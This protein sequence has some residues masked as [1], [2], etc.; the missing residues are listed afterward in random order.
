MPKPAY[1]AGG[2]GGS[3]DRWAGE[4]C[5]VKKGDAL[6]GGKIA[7]GEH[8]GDAHAGEEGE[9]EATDGTWVTQSEV[10][11]WLRPT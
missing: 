10:C 8:R 9:F 6:P 1:F 5:L 7:T 3:F 2:S 11:K 4:S